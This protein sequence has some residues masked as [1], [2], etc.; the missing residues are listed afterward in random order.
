LDS[1][2]SRGLDSMGGRGLDSM[3]GRGLDSMGGGLGGGGYND[4]GLAS[5]GGRRDERAGPRATRPDNCTVLVKNLPYAVTWQD[6]KERFQ[7]IGEV[8]FA[9]IKLEKGRS[10]GQ[11]LVRFSTEDDALRA[12]NSMDQT[13]FEGRTIEV[14][15]YRG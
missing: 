10:T 14:R 4:S 11:G 8:K 7:E 13:R 5:R 15:M 1:M 3:G 12:I 6:L 2:G 9:E